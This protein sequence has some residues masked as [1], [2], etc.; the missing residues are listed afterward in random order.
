MS[1][2]L[3]NLIPRVENLLGN[4]TTTTRTKSGISRCSVRNFETSAFAT[5]KISPF[6]APR[7]SDFP[8]GPDHLERQKMRFHVEALG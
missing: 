1:F 2:T 4:L 8:S 3:L 6:P 5:P 7:S